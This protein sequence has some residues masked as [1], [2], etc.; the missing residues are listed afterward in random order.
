MRRIQ[1]P[2]STLPVSMGL[3]HCACRA[4]RRIVCCWPVLDYAC[5]QISSR[6]PCITG[7]AD[8][9][10]GGKKGNTLA[11]EMYTPW[12]WP[13]V[14]RHAPTTYCTVPKINTTVI[15]SNTSDTAD[16]PG[17]YMRNSTNCA[18]PPPCGHAGAKRPQAE[19]AQA[20]GVRPKRST[21][22]SAKAAAAAS[23]EID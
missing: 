10:K 20:V 5:E 9:A 1:R 11:G 13:L 12:A 15:R 7:G 17:Q 21:K 6:I 3:E 18:P 19:D 14:P 22:P 4:G 2:R 8:K 16:N 23:I